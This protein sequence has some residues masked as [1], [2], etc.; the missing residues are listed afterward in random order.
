[1]LKMISIILDSSTFS[2][3]PW[4]ARFT[5]LSAWMPMYIVLAMITTELR[6]SKALLKRSSARILRTFF[7]SGWRLPGLNIWLAP[8]ANA[9]FAAF[10]S[11]AFWFLALTFPRPKD[12]STEVLPSPSNSSCEIAAFE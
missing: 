6:V 2:S 4:I 7:L 11:L 3:P 5:W 10:L 8:A 9:S 12:L 1:V